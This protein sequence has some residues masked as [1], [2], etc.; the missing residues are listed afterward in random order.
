MIRE[1]EVIAHDVLGIADDDEE[2]EVVGSCTTRR[3]ED[4]EVALFA[5][6]V[7]TH[8]GEG[9]VAH[10]SCHLLW[11]LKLLALLAGSARLRSPVVASFTDIKFLAQSGR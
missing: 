1:E 2:H 11:G 3:G 10:L 6:I 7:N 5:S 9:V 4:D 8:L